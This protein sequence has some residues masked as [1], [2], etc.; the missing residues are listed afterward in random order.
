MKKGYLFDA[1]FAVDLGASV[2]YRKV[3]TVEKT[4]EPGGGEAIW[5][6]IYFSNNEERYI[7]LNAAAKYDEVIAWEQS[8]PNDA[9]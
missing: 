3:L 6:T 2:K 5:L 4:K 1:I 8:R 7:S 9:E